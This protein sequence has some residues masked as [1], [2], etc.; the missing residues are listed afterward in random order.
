LARETAQ[1]FFTPQR[2]QY[3]SRE[4]FQGQFFTTSSIESVADSVVRE[5]VQN[6]LDAHDGSSDR[7]LIVFRLHSTPGLPTVDVAPFLDGLWP[8]LEACKEGASDLQENGHCPTLVIEDFNTRGLVG[9]PARWREPEDKRTNDFY[10]FFRAEGKSSKSGATRG[11][12]GIGKF[13]FVQASEVNT[14]FGFTHRIG[15]ENQPG[16]PGPLVMG[17]AIMASHMLDGEAF[18]PD[19]WWAVNARIDGF[20]TPMPATAGEQ[21]RRFES[22]FKL[23][24]RDQPGLSV[25]VP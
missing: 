10:Y 25:V 5:A 6:T 8:H 24:R 23:E 17:E 11:S 7:P 14:F 3:K 2:P 9:D 18:T 12:W 13:T 16:G 4:A 21:A 20:E 1:W 19:G 15:P 22:V